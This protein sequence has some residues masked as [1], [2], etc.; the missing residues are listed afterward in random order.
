MANDTA[1]PKRD[2]RQ[3]LTDRIIELVEQG[4]A[5]WQKPWSPDAAS[6]FLALPH[7]AATGRAYRG[8]NAVWLMMKGQA[9]GSADPR[10]CTY[11]QAQEA[12]WQVRKGSKGTSVEYWQFDREED[13]LNPATGKTEKVKVKLDN[14][15]V[16]YATVFHASQ[17]DGIPEY[18]PR[19]R[20]DSWNPIDEAERILS[21]SGAKIHHDQ[22]DAAYYA[23]GPDD[24]HLP[25][26]EAFA[27]PLDYYEVALHE[28]GHWTGHASRLARDLTGSFGS[29]AYAREELRAQMSSLFL[30]A[31]LGVPF[32][33]ERHA[34][35]Q[36]SWVKVL[37]ED[38]H[39]IF[40]AARD[41]EQI[42]DY[43]VGLA[44]ERT[45]EVRQTAGADSAISAPSQQPS[46]SPS[47][48]VPL[49]V[50]QVQA[51][52]TAFCEQY[53]VAREVAYRVRNTLEDLYGPNFQ[54]PGGGAVKA[55]FRPG[56]FDAEG[57]FHR[58]RCDIP[59]ANVLDEGDLGQ[60]LRHEIIGHYGINTFGA[61]A[62]RAV[63][64]AIIRARHEPGLT[65]LWAKADTHYPETSELVRAEEVYAFAC[66]TIESV[67]R[68][69]LAA[70]E[71]SILDTCIKPVRSMQLL[72][73]SL[74]T[75]YVAAG[76]HERTRAQQVFPLPGEQFRLA[77]NGRMQQQEVAMA[78]NELPANER[79]IAEFAAAL[80]EH[81]LVLDGPPVMDGEIHNVPVEGNKPGRTSGWYMA[82]L[83][84][85]PSGFIGNYLKGV[86][87]RW[88][89]S[90]IVLNLT[91][92]DV[93]AAAERK[94][95]K[96]EE[97]VAAQEQ[98]AQWVAR[99]WKS[100]RVA[101]NS[102]GYLQRKGVE[103][104]G[105]KL[106]KHGNLVMPLQ[107]IDGKLW[108]VQR[109]SPDGGKLFTKGGRT[110]GCFSPVGAD[111][112]TQ[113]IVIAEG[114][115]TSASVHEVT[116]LPVV[117]ALNAGNLRPVAEAFRAK[118]P[119]RPIF[120]AGDNDHVKEAEGKPNVGKMKSA[121]AAQ[122]V[123]GYS[124]LPDFKPDDGGT[125]WN[126]LAKSEG[127]DA[128]RGQIQAVMAAHGISLGRGMLE[129]RTYLKV[130][131]AERDVAKGLG[132]RWDGQRKSW[133]VPPGAE[134]APF[135]KWPVVPTPA[136]AVKAEAPVAS[137]DGAT[138]NQP[139][140]E[141]APQEP[142]V[143][144]SELEHELMDV[145]GHIIT[146]AKA[147][148]PLDAQERVQAVQ[149]IERGLRAAGGSDGDG[150][151]SA[152]LY[153][154]DMLA[155]HDGKLAPAT[156]NPF[157]EEGARQRYEEYRDHAEEL[158]ALF[159]AEPGEMH[160]DAGAVTDA[161]GDSAADLP[162]GDVLRAT[163][164]A[165][166]M[167]GLDAGTAPHANR[168]IELFED[169]RVPAHTMTLAQFSNGLHVEPDSE[170][171][172]WM[173]RDDDDGH[174]V[175]RVPYEHKG[176]LSEARA[177]AVIAAAHEVSVD[178]ALQARAAGQDVAVP[179]EVLA[180]YPDLAQK[181]GAAG[182]APAALHDEDALRA[183]DPAVDLSQEQGLDL[184]RT[185][186]AT[187]AVHAVDNA[188]PLPP[189]ADSVA[190]GAADSANE[191]VVLMDG[192]SAD[193]ADARKPANDP[194]KSVES[195]E[196]FVALQSV[197]T[198]DFPGVE[199]T[200]TVGRLAARL[201]ETPTANDASALKPAND[202]VK[203]VAGTLSDADL[204]RVRRSREADTAA[205][206]AMLAGKSAP[207]A[208]VAS[209][210]EENA[211][212]AADAPQLDAQPAPAVAKELANA[213]PVLT[214]S[215]YGVPASVASRYVVRDGAFW[216]F[217]GKD[218]TP[219]LDGKPHFEDKGPKL[220]T[221]SDDR[222][223]IADMVAVAQAKNWSAVQVKGS[224]DFRR[225][226]WLEAR[227]AGLE[228]K[229]FEP[230]EADLALLEAAQRE[231]DGLRIA[232]GEAPTSVADANTMGVT[233]R[234]AT[235]RPAEAASQD[236]MPVKDVRAVFEKSIQTF[237]ENVRRELTTRFNARLKM[238]VE[239]Q[240][241]VAKGELP[242]QG[243]GDAI[244]ASFADL[245]KAWDA[246]AQDGATAGPAQPTASPAGQKVGM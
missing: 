199:S 142:D 123:G 232:A 40:R 158:G 6:S 23:A 89:S 174:P 107:D 172:A 66:E 35:Y 5:P 118:Y 50:A 220:T 71:Q 202:P 208:P 211:I 209:Q 187:P 48:G 178:R 191:P 185:V 60:T 75:Q 58:G 120:I 81:G 61:A 181:Y 203:P 26:R 95:A 97:R 144:P 86:K 21:G 245:K 194:V 162:K 231:R 155:A 186:E 117:C 37:K 14:P 106:D 79:V 189:S 169:D 88:V 46:M 147:D 230:K 104:H 198:G 70:A 33:P 126:D 13:R 34:A 196:P 114:Y 122:A 159:G 127:T 215:G 1:Q 214:T 152:A 77:D 213:K 243:L 30:S 45:L 3:D 62:K 146:R 207:A 157:A 225:H 165:L 42:A 100:L 69:D 128:V 235:T 227:V 110:A 135:E 109:I 44:H 115:A 170:S 41:A 59:A 56:Y 82:S 93:A 195:A 11:R 193:E 166:G 171:P 55:G 149:L 2:F 38:K 24:I 63:L 148:R 47:T 161:A 125:D 237:P 99:E 65:E 7:N 9:L 116:G 17:I 119:G 124:L 103:N 10:W 179:D 53:P 43:V 67:P 52:I 217:D 25:P 29:E 229:G 140:E 68:I 91:P 240:A 150:A 133:Y 153:G 32:N 201:Q 160:I 184:G 139:S 246:P 15:R 173:V 154:V 78:D 31:E 39:E 224:E 12:G 138:L 64:E 176:L 84:G 238:G 188:E 111:D 94:R 134:L 156:E 22:Q 131:Y 102:H 54:A 163:G 74:I 18:A 236:S 241:K 76:L 216:K 244:G 210:S 168:G 218:K 212:E 98:R 205:A 132:A 180:E 182:E 121:D 49:S 16:F 73:L 206:A 137:T 83:D 85:Q 151:V 234:T 242:K 90:G 197:E 233:E 51:Q 8:G 192:P 221:A 141:D 20:P 108:S 228:V 101:P 28:L 143:P 177:D 222:K 190:P 87:E 164:P 226:A 27:E 219:A 130:P 57:H 112:P 239:L 96:A 175:A 72:D 223:T 129:A 36:R 92:A 19:R 113:P 167:S 80:K 136:V 204:E 145:A 105:L 4:M 200:G 183:S